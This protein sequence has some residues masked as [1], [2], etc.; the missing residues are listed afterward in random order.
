VKVEHSRELTV[1]ILGV[2]PRG[3]RPA[4]PVDGC[5]ADGLERSTPEEVGLLGSTKELARLF[6]QAATEVER[7]GNV[8]NLEEAV[9]P[10]LFAFRA[11]SC[12]TVLAPKPTELSPPSQ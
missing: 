9:H 3:T 8:S 6:V 4:P 10:V 2:K 5:G 1:F 12:T 11:V 7:L